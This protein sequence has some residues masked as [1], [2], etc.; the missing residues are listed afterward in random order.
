MYSCISSNSFLGQQAHFTTVDNMGVNRNPTVP[1]H[2]SAGLLS[3]PCSFVRQPRCS[4]RG[5]YYSGFS[6][7]P[8]SPELEKPKIAGYQD[9]GSPLSKS[10]SLVTIAL[11]SNFACVPQDQPASALHHMLT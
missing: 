3:P 6:L 2:P 9:T 10:D 8:G 4:E 7:G 11:H 1:R 5:F